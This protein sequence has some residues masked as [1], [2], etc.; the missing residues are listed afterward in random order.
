MQI[1]KQKFIEMKDLSSD[2]NNQ[3]IS[4]QAQNVIEHENKHFQFVKQ[5]SD[6]GLTS[7]YQ[8]FEPGINKSRLE[9]THE[10]VTFWRAWLIPRV[11][12]YA[13]TLFCV[14]LAVNSMLLWLPLM[15]KE[16]LNYHTY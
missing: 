2:W 7:K 8:E 6:S 1:Q 5:G 10:R 14:K 16:Y 4:S 13:S 15:L 9:P 11:F 3:P 12:I